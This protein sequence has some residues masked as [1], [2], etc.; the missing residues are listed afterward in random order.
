MTYQSIVHI[1]NEIR[2]ILHTSRQVNLAAQN[3]SLAARRAGNAW[4]FQAVSI[5]LKTFSQQ[6]GGAMG[7]MSGD[8][9]AIA[10]GVS[11]NYRRHRIFRHQQIT[12]KNSAPSAALTSAFARSDDQLKA[13]GK[14]LAGR[15]R[16]LEM[17]VA[18]SLRL[19]NNGRALARSA[20]I[21]ATGG[22]ASQGILRHVAHDIE[23]TIEDIH[24]RL[25][26][27]GTCLRHDLERA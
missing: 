10:Q 22:G 27:I 18:Q 16:G 6:L 7:L 1:S 14:L 5:E 15:L 8:I 4:G 20:M 17:R 9:H 13:I 19:C 26:N 2:F 24:Q 25:K 11:A 23:H 12:L 3:A 21:E